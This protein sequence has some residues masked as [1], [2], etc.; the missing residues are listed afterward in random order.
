MI[1]RTFGNI[2]GQVS[3]LGFGAMRMPLNS[4]D[5]KDIDVA[6]VT[7]MI[8]A[9]IEGGVN[10]FDT[11]VPY[12]GEQS[13]ST[14]RKVLVDRYE[15]SSFYLATKLPLWKCESYKDYETT[16]SNQLKNLGVDYVDFYL[17]HALNRT[18]IEQ[19]MEIGMLDFIQSLKRDGKAKHIGFSYHDDYSTFEKFVSEHYE[20][21]D[22]IQLQLNY[23]DWDVLETGKCYDLCVKYNIP[24]IVMEPVKGGRLADISPRINGLLKTA[25]PDKSVASWA[26]SYA[27]SCPNV[28]TVLSGMSDMEQIDDNMNTILNFEPL[29]DEDYAILRNV[30]KEIQ[31]MELIPCTG[32]GYCID[33]PVGINI[34]NMFTLFNSVQTGKTIFDAK[35]I[36]MAIDAGNR[37]N[38]CIECGNCSSICPQNIKIPENL[39]K[40]NGILES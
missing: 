18:R 20:K 16:F 32:C 12:H 3:L 37:A 27:A 13:E 8:D 24:V 30:V 33:C 29:S 1:K 35:K 2:D 4:D 38:R 31:S 6:T 9:A 26:I 23:L 10:Y 22:F 17:L 34:P 15:R 19:H 21:F 28:M 25:K 39:K 40:I 11:A 14:L 5:T 36:Y 7:K